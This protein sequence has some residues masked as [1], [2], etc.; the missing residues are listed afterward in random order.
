MPAQRS[1][2]PLRGA[3]LHIYIPAH[4]NARECATSVDPFPSNGPTPSIGSRL[5]SVREGKRKLPEEERDE[6]SRKA[7]RK[8]LQ[9]SR[10]GA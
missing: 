1:V 6:R 7:S 3:P 8:F 9:L 4:L 10:N 5:A 2:K